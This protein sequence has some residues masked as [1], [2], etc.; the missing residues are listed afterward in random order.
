MA[1]AEGSSGDGGVVVVVGAGLAGMTAAIRA[2]ENL[3]CTVIV[4]DKEERLGG[5]SAKATS[6]MNAAGVYACVRGA[7]RRHHKSNAGTPPQAAASVKDTF[8]VFVDDT[9]K[10]GHGECDEA[11]VARLASD[12]ADAWQFIGQHGE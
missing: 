9:M 5:N 2:A 10:S 12:S 1:A 6:G 8:E 11:M 7:S 3:K 4:Y